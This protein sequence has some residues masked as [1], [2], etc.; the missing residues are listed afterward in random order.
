[1]SA[2]ELHPVLRAMIPVARGIAATFGNQCEVVLHDLSRPRTSI[3]EIVN[4]AVTGRNVGDGIRELVWSVLRSPSFTDDMLTNYR[5][6]APDGRDVKS[7]TVLI[8]DEANRIVGALCINLDLSAFSNMKKSLDDL[9]RVT[10]LGP[11]P[12]KVIQV[13]NADV[14]DVLDH[15]AEG[16]IEE[17]RKPASELSREEKI[18]IVRYLDEKGVFRIRGSVDRIAGKLGTSRYTIYNYLGSVRAASEI[19]KL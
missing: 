15:I 2:E 6:T 13:K 18:E 17:Y 9:T 1:L 16:T 7:T 4:N 19:E 3:V 8:R 5:T 14:I 10:Q 11:P 12:D